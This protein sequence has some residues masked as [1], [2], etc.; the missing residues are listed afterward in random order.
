MMRALGVLFIAVVLAACGD[1]GGGGGGG[2]GDGAT[3][4]VG[5]P[6]TTV[7]EG[8]PPVT[9]VWFGTAYDSANMAIYDKGSTFKAGGPLVAVATLL[10]PR[11]PADLE[12]TVEINGS[13]KAK[14][15]PGPGGTGSTYGVD[16]S[17]QKF[18]PG[19]YLISFKSKAGK[20]LASASV[21]ITA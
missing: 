18:A 3:G 17:G 4:L 8:V 12:I 14:V 20:S 13:V 21:T 1:G 7:T 2:G 5:G 10:T 11:D 6:G 15:P 19:S 16:L 9:A